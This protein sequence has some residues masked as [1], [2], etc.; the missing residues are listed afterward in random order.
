MFIGFSSWKKEKEKE[1]FKTQHH[2]GRG[3]RK[4]TQIR[5]DSKKLVC[6]QNAS[7]IW[8]L[9]SDTLV[10]FQNCKLKELLYSVNQFLCEYHQD[11]KVT[12]KEGVSRADVRR[13]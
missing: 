1:N 13:V 8:N 3:V 12:A 6:Q 5:K 7:K 2:T 11:H 9:G 4:H 10:M